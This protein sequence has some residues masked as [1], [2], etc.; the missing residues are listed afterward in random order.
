MDNDEAGREI[1]QKSEDRI[2]RKM[3]GHQLIEIGDIRLD[4]PTQGIWGSPKQ[5]DKEFLRQPS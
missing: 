4:P 1:K 3:A 5:S 2:N